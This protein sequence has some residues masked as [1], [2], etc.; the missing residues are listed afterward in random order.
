MKK[1]N[2]IKRLLLAGSIFAF[3]MPMQTQCGFCKWFFKSTPK[4]VSVKEK[5]AKTAGF[6]GRFAKSKYGI[7]AFAG[8]LV[9]TAAAAKFYVKD[10][11]ITINKN[12]STPFYYM[13]NVGL[14]LLELSQKSI[15]A[16]LPFAKTALGKLRIKAIQAGLK[17]HLKSAANFIIDGIKL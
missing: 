9:A 17:K 4:K 7:R 3:S 1:I 2:T 6:L 11:N 12:A 13:K 5:I 16:L 14:T 15:F 10:Q 8:I